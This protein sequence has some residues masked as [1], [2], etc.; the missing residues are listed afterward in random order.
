MR[1]GPCLS[2][3]LLYPSSQHS[4]AHSSHLKNTYRMNELFCF[5]K[6]G[7]PMPNTFEARQ[8]LARG[9]QPAKVL[10]EKNNPE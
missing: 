8:T 6:S 9:K 4:T 10:Q 7:F 3:S 1:T 5:C 2:Y